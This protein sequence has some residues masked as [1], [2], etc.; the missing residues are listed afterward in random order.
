M[1]ELT[2]A[3][4]K[5]R[6]ISEAGRMI[7]QANE[8]RIKKVI[9]ELSSILEQLNAGTAVEPKE[10]QKKIAEAMDLYEAEFSHDDKR[11]LLRK[12]VRER[13]NINTLPGQEVYAWIRDVYDTSVVYERGE[14]LYKCSY[15][16]DENGKVT[17]G[18]PFEVV[19]E[20][21]YKAVKVVSESGT[22]DLTVDFVPLT[23]VEKSVRRDGTIP[24]KIIEP[25]WGSSGYY[26]K[27]VLE[28]DGPKVFTKGT[29]MFWNHPTPTEEME[30]PER[31]LND[32]AAEFVSD[33][34][35]QENGP[36]G[37]GL[38][39]DAKVFG[40]YKKAVDEL[41]PHIGASI[42]ALGKAKMGEAEGKTGPIIEQIALAKSV[43][44]VTTPGAGGQIL[45][46]FEAARGGNTPLP[47]H[48]VTLQEFKRIRP[49]LVE[50]MRAELK[51][52]VYGEKNQFEEAK[53][54]KEEEIRALE[55]SKRKT[56]EEN[57]R[58]KEALILRDAKDFV[59]G[60]LSKVEMPELTRTRLV[61]SLAKNPVVKEG[62]LDKD[63]FGKKITEAVKTELEYLAKVTGSGQIHG[64]GESVSETGEVKLAEVEKTLENSFLRLGLSEGAAKTAAKGREV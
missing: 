48:T 59:I 41:A 33:A 17:L 20:T 29:K 15:L 5:L 51:T 61:E 26:P 53:R 38:Y 62:S 55:E 22:S 13:E 57:A 43:D 16:V 24:L 35:W 58:L 7:S 18:D 12:A 36:A 44:F 47:I 23:L 49:D 2:R 40:P 19:V 8:G 10:K 34:T 3:L 60:A 64:M 6:S 54:V 4:G 45:Q 39:T 30:R 25:G 21:T 9:H 50:E 27:E 1:N 28:R 11:Q 42:R 32:L 31:D 14:K 52:A 37:A 56:D 63:E 46:L